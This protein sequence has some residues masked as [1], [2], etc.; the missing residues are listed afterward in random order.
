MRL[1]GRAVLAGT[2]LVAAAATSIGPARATNDPY[3][4]EQWALQRINAP[5]AW[6]LSTGAGVR[7]GIV[8][9]G[10]DLTHEDLASKVVASVSCIGANDFEGGCSGSAQ[11]DNGHGTHVAGIAAAVTGNG[12]GIAG[13][14]P[15]ASLVVVKALGA[16][17]SG[18]LNDVNAGIKW[19]VDHGARVINLSL[20]SDGNSVAPVAGQSLREGVEYAW[21]NG[22]IPVIAAGNSTPSLFGPNGYSGIDAVIVGATGSNDE[23]AWYSS[24]LAGAKWGVV[25]P[26]GDERDPDGDAS[27]AGALAAGCIVSTGWFAGHSNQYADDEGTSMAAPHVSGVLALLLAQGLT[28]TAAVKRML[29]TTD[30]VACGPGCAGRVDAAAAVGAKVVAPPPTTAAPPTIPVT[31]PTT[32]TV[33]PQPAKTGG[34]A[35][36]V[37]APTPTTSTSIT[38]HPTTSVPPVRLAIPPLSHRN[39]GLAAWPVILAVLALLGVVSFGAAA[40]PTLRA[41]SARREL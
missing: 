13:V 16:S 2:I 8:D 31:V 14:A 20:E 21:N 4:P 32:T 10:I 33:A 5:A 6:T 12:K 34:T 9:T 19:A 26:G 36:P 15:G 23:V 35:T 29:D 11:D 1:V 24:P 28:P 37:R 39:H 25:A 17:G 22:A 3:F 18:A 41:T 30:V 27:C 40:A 38:P 7:I